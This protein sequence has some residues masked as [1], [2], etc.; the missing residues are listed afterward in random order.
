MGNFL[1]DLTDEL[2]CKELNCKVQNCPGHWIAEF[3]SCG[4]KNYSYKLNSG[5][6][7]CKVRGFSLNHN[8]SLII[9]FDSMKNALDQ[10]LS[11]DSCSTPLVTVKT[12]ILRNK[13][14]PIVYNRVVEKHYGVV[15]DKRKIIEDYRTVPFGFKQ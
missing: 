13:H 11:S 7:V 8:A 4:P 1:G 12:E 9:N 6:T 10:W 3:V 15:Y 14:V 5:E 2:T